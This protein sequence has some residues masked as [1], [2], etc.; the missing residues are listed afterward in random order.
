MLKGTLSFNDNGKKVHRAVNLVN[1]SFF[2]PLK[3][4]LIHEVHCWPS[5]PSTISSVVAFGDLEIVLI[6]V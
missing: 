6:T 4:N 1:W 2:R 3:L 5:C